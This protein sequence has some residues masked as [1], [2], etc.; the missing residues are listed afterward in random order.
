MVNCKTNADDCDI[1]QTT[2]KNWLGI[3]ETLGIIFYLHPYSNNV[4]K[5]TVKTPKLYF[6]DTGLVC[7]LTKWSDTET[8]M[9][10]AMSG[11]I[12]ENFAVSEIVKSYYNCG[13]E[14]FVYYYRD[15][16]TK[17]ID[18]IIEG[19]GK[20][21][22]IEIKKTA[23]PDIRLT[24]VFKVIDKSPLLRGTGAVLCTAEKLSAFDKDNLIVPIGLI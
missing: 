8:L 18:L 13:R 2:A 16:D 11:A 22:P 17:E 9:N 15:K 19:N 4:L 14:P 1:D 21:Y 7:F 24:R 6:Y 5:R 20:L 3:L 23:T 12:L 10:G